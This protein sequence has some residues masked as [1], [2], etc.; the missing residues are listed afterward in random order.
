MNMTTEAEKARKEWAIVIL[1]A[2]GI[3][4]DAHLPAYRKAGFQVTGIYDRIRDRANQLAEEFHVQQIYSSMEDALQQ[5]VGKTIFDVALPAAAFVD[6]L[7]AMPDGA[8]VLLQ[9]PMGQSLPEAAAI[10]D[11]CRG[12]RLTLAVNFQLRFAPAIAK[13]REMIEQGCIGEL[14]DLEVRVTVFTPWS[15]WTFLEVAPRVEILYHSIHYID[16]MRSFLGDPIGVYARTVKH[17]MTIKLASTRSNIILNYGDKIRSS[18]STNHDHNYGLEHQESYVKWEGT[19]GAIKVQLG[20]L[21]DYPRGRPDIFEYVQTESVQDSQWRAVEIPGSWFPD[22]FIGSMG[23][24][25]D[26]LSGYSDRLP[27]SVEDAYKTMAVVEAAYESDSSGGTKVL[28][29]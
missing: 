25:M 20:I 1:G 22:A 7:N 11:L 29:A 28:Y 13:A 19:K 9:K 12:K 17:P 8:A 3:V 27:T 6:V 14:H 16:L 21:M 15:L 5:P 2:G 4:H 26:Y 24:L 23:S 18:I 10:R